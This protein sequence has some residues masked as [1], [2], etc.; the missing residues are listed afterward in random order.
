MPPTRRL[1]QQGSAVVLASFLAV[2]SSRAATTKPSVREIAKRFRERPSIRYEELR[3]Q[4]L[5]HRGGE[6]GRTAQARSRL[7]EPW[8]RGNG[9]SPR[10]H[11]DGLATIEPKPVNPLLDPLG[12]FEG[13]TGEEPPIGPLPRLFLADFDGDGD[14]DAF[15][16][17]K[18]GYVRYLR[19][20][21]PPGGEP[22]YVELT[23]AASP[24]GLLDLSFDDAD[25]MDTSPFGP[26][27]PTLIDVDGDDDLDLF[28]GQGYYDG[29]GTGGRV[30]FFENVAGT[31]T[32]NDDDNPFDGF[33][34]GVGGAAPTF[35]DVDEDGDFDAF[36]GTKAEAP[37]P[38]GGEVFFLRNEGDANNP[39]LVDQ[40]DVVG[41]DPFAGVPFLPF[42]APYFADVDGDGDPDGFVGNAYATRFFRNDTMLPG[43]PVFPEQT[44][45][46]NPLGG[47]LDLAP[48]P[49]LA[50]VDGDG[51]LDAFVGLGGYGAKD[52]SFGFLQYFENTG[53]PAGAAFLAP[54]D[55]LELV[56]VDGDGD[57]DALAS[58]L[59]Y[60][61][62]FE[63]GP[64]GLKAKAGAP[65]EGLAVW[66]FRNQ[67][68]P[69]EPVW[70][71]QS[72]AANPFFTF[73][74]GYG[75]FDYSYSIPSVAP[76]VGHLDGDALLDAFVGTPYGY[77][78][79]LED[80]GSG[81]LD[82]AA[83]HPLEAFAFGY[84][85]SPDPHLADVNGDGEL[86]LVVGY[87][88]YNDGT[89]Y[90]DSKVAFF[91]NPTGPA[92][93]DGPPN[94]VLDLTG[95]GLDRPAPTLADVDGDGD[96]DLL[97]G[98]Y[99]FEPDGGSRFPETLFIENTG[100]PTAPAFSVASAVPV[101]ALVNLPSSP[102]MGDV[103]GDGALDLFLG[104]LAGAEM[105]LTAVPRLEVVKTVTGGNLAPGGTIQYTITLSN[106]GTETQPDDP[107]DPELTDTLP[108]QLTL[109]SANLVIG[110]GSVSVDLGA[111]SLRY[112]GELDPGEM[113]T[114]VVT[115]QI[116]EGTLGTLIA[117]Q[118]T[119]FFDA[120]ADG[121]NDT[122]EPS[123][124]PATMPDNDPTGF[125]VVAAVP[126]LSQWGAALLAGLLSL[127]G[128]F[129]L[130]RFD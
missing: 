102:A 41:L 107:T 96:L 73:N 53:T 21:A 121:E 54:G 36:V 86:D 43:P 49:V 23:G 115:A 77:L 37:S 118:A 59:G 6:R 5:D 68:T 9:V 105:F 125:V 129:G 123:D 19:S 52:Y 82:P 3:R 108:P 83:T 18:Y 81:Q 85:S 56:D 16:G 40:T 119:A 89:A 8:S 112:D 97:V 26:S 114:I 46:E 111:N 116:D 38:T 104:N 80:D 20:V 126:T 124:D 70:Q 128:L 22:E 127:L 42:T 29:P 109:L 94:I 130:R 71:L 25:P 69:G 117:N 78:E 72:G 92:G 103:N 87:E 47:G 11:A 45:Y 50:D 101:E 39:L 95:T 67:G 2:S 64:P 33:L 51:D 14:L 57:L 60:T 34:F 10:F 90:Y 62:L 113:A 99:Y 12:W 79:F 91:L 28:V 66:Y 44:G 58:H 100:T 74:T 31:L 32:R 27:A 106:T 88:P 65:G 4:W 98:G 76:T 120:N 122:E 13:E 24:T 61:G 7:A 75:Y 63:A 55:R 1:A 93:L 84:G 30:L 35:V 110:P 48:G 17:D 15:V